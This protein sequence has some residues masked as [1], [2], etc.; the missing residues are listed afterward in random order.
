MPE[1]FPFM[2]SYT[3]AFDLICTVG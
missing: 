1:K 3:D 2:L